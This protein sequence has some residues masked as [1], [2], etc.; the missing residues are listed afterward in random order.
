MNRIS[1]AFAKMEKQLAD[2]LE[3]GIVTQKQVDKTNQAL[4]MDAIEYC[5]LQEYKSLAVADGT[6]SLE[7]GQTAFA[8]LGNTLEHFNNQPVHIKAVLTQIFKE[9]LGKQLA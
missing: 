9:L 5:K 3:N 2:R 4:D 1:A 6:L 7:E 8:A